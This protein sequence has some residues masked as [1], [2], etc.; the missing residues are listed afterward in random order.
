MEQIPLKEKQEQ[1]SVLLIEDNPGDQVII[2]SYLNEENN[3][4]FMI[5]SSFNLSGGLKLLN[6]AKYDVVILDLGLPDSSGL[7]GLKKIS[8]VND[9]IPVIVLT[10]DN[11]DDTGLAAINSGAQ[12][13]IAKN[14]IQYKNLSRSIRYAI[15]RK[16]L[17]I[18]LKS[19]LS[20]YENTFEQAQVGFA[21]ISPNAE[22]IK[23][24]KKFCDILGYSSSEL[25]GKSINDITYPDDLEKDLTNLE[26]IISGKLIS[27]KIEKRFLHKNGFVIWVNMSRTAIFDNTNEI[28]YF[29]TTIEDITERK[30]LEIELQKSKTLL[31]NIFEVLPVGICI[32]NYDGTLMGSNKKFEEIWG[33]SGYNNLDDHKNHKGWLVDSNKEITGEEWASCRALKN[34]EIT[35]GEIIKIQCFD[36]SKKTIINSALPI[37]KEDKVVNAIAVVE[38][39][40]KLAEIEDKLKDEISQKEML[41][42]ET[43]H[44]IKNNLQLMSSFINLQLANV[45]NPEISYILKDSLTRIA[46]ISLLHNYLYRSSNLNQINMQEYLY[47]IIDQVR[48]TLESTSKNINIV[49]D[50]ADFQA[51]SA[52]AI[53]IGLI[54]NELITNAVK[55]AFNDEHDKNI[56][57]GIKPV[58]DEILFIFSDN[59]KGMDKN[60]DFSSVSTL[61]LQI[62]DSLITQHNGTIYCEVNNGTKFTI[63][64]PLKQSGKS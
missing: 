47:Q 10:I 49:K 27:Y 56:Y 3:Y 28:K 63:K 48:G 16:N 46:S 25:L 24:N 7:N 12:D 5:K 45:K 2:K 57:L 41:I 22:F 33:S 60:I 54:L 20:L 59:G 43:N 34:K 29:F 30:S 23:L 21:H 15:S 42:K 50:I 53:S 52:L 14:D 31:E 44:R 17:E 36:G 32:F 4:E 51:G 26:K 9:A 19:S 39:I 6:E 37:I 55:H 13:Y 18:K 8:R 64:L 38:D 58:N 11:S 35:L 62:I 1:I 61:G 40:S